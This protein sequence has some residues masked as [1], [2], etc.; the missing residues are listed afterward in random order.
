M[1][2]SNIA[3]S[4][5][6]SGLVTARV[7][8]AERITPHM[9]RL[10]LAGPELERWRHLGFDQW[11]R[12]AIPV[13]GDRTRFDRLS[14]RFDMRG[15]LR[16]LTLPKA[17]RPEI[18]NYTVRRFR[19]DGAAGPE[20]DIDFVVHGES[21]DG[22][23]AAGD[24]GAARD[25]DAAGGADGGVAGPWAA[26]LPVG[27]HVALIDQGCGYR[28]VADATRVVL[29]GDESALPAV[30]GILRD[31]PRDAVGDAIIEVPDD[32][33]RQPDDA[34]EGVR[35]QWVARSPGARPGAAALDA[36]TALPQWSE[37][38]SAFVAGE[39]QLAAGGRRHLVGERGVPKS[40]VDFCG[41]WRQGKRAA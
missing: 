21:T 12:L 37:P 24:A 19:P 35:L 13:A 5:A 30:L 38:V 4:H 7:A 41:Y 28:P 10:T 14:D 8:R 31:L 11:F 16:Y 26:S 32:A 9:A 29:A 2:S 20:L 36:L 15:Y 18:R 1:P 22:V 27:A 23:A 39:Q 40:A 25:A 6:A 3:V 17:S 34:P 33:D